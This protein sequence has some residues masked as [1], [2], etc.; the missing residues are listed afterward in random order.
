MISDSSNHPRLCKW[1]TI[2][3]F[4][5]VYTTTARLLCALLHVTYQL[6]RL[7]F[8]AYAL[9]EELN[10]RPVLVSLANENW[11]EIPGEKR[12]S[13]KDTWE[14]F[15]DWVN[16]EKLELREC[17]WQWIARTLAGNDSVRNLCAYLNSHVCL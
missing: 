11:W 10:K 17:H 7:A 16:P 2:L 14:R 4:S 15:G 6:F 5:L 9:G 12:R 1:A 3:D 8:H 13:A